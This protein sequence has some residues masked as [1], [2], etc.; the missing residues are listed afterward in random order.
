MITNTFSTH[1]LLKSTQL[2]DLFFSIFIGYVYTCT[3]DFELTILPSMAPPHFL[4]YWVRN[5][6]PISL[7]LLA[8][9][10]ECS[11]GK[12]RTKFSTNLC[13]LSTNAAANSE[14]EGSNENT[15]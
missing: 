10:S 13:Y 1:S 5:Y 9:Y 4:S 11:Q 3:V 12:K 8:N 14:S 2:Y 6:L 15:E 7:K